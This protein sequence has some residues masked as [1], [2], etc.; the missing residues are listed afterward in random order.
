MKIKDK[1]N[2]D[3]KGLIEHGPINIVALGDSVTHGC[4]CGYMDYEA[5]Y[6][7]RLR[8]K[9]LEVRD[10]VPVNVINAGIGG[11]T[12]PTAVLRMEKQ[13]FTH[14]PDLVIVC[15]GLNDVNGPLERYLDSLE[16]I[17][18]ECIA[19]EVDVI[20][21]TPNMLNT[22]LSDKTPE[23]FIDYAA[24]TAKMQNEG[25]MDLYIGSAADLAR[26][27]GVTVCDCYSRW[28]ELAKTQDIT[29]LLANR[30]N[31]PTEEMHEL[32]ADM[33]FECIFD[34]KG[35]VCENI[36]SGMYKEDK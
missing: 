21:M 34:D 23:K 36:E 2:L 6:W 22:S 5:A 7:N 33:L 11:T 4:F 25:R 31:H 20:F 3:V 13:V 30:I 16:K 18:S 10:Y 9:I 35:E 26:K 12:A 14:L 15:F 17:F 29:E 1:I 8:K 28:K 32:F 24:K 19:R 27:M